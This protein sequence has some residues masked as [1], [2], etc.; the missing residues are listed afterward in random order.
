MIITLTGTNHFLLQQELSRLIQDFVAKHGDVN[1]ERLDGEEVLVAR[2]IEATQSLPFLADKKLVILRNPSTQKDFAEQIESVISRVPEN[3]D[4]VL[5]EPKIDKR[6]SYFKVLKAKTEYREY[7]EPDTYQLNK[8]IVQ[9]VKQQG[10]EISTSDSQYLV[11]RVGLN[12]QI[13]YKELEKLLDFNTKIDRNS[14]DLLTDKTP[15]S[16]IFELLDAAFA[17]N[18]AK[19]IELYRQQRSL[20][21]EPQQIM[22]MLAWQLHVLAV[23]KTAGNKNPEQIAKESKINPYVVRKTT[24]IASLITLAD[25]RNLIKRALDLDLRLKSQKID[26]DLAIKH[27]LLTIN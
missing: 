27:F 15:Q 22:A 20:R 11:D 18:G 12:Q 21:V 9:Y 6:S 1:L 8:W 25:L 5:V 3:V 19:T 14:I 10:G 13:L 26:A 7:V 17:G 2:L 23:V 4:L 24:N 16:T